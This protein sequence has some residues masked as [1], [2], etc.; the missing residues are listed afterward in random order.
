[1]NRRL[2]QDPDLGG[3]PN[4]RLDTLSELKLVGRSLYADIKERG[5][6]LADGEVNPSVEAHRKNA[7][8]QLCFLST[9]AELKRVQKSD[10]V[11]LV[12]LMAQQA[13]TV[14]TDESA[15]PEKPPA[16]F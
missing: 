10:A 13:E 15:E 12:S 4:H 3:M 6:V 7:H 2:R 16:N 1:M 14:E 8:E 11:D 9:I 5:A